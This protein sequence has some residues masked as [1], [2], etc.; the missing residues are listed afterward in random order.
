VT[1]DNDVL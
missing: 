1:F